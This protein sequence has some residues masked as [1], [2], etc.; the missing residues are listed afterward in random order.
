MQDQLVGRSAQVAVV[1]EES[2]QSVHQ[3][4]VVLAIVF[5]QLSQSF[6]VETLQL[7]GAL[8]ME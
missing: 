1:G 7:G 6:L 4:A 5:H 2:S 8:E 3:F